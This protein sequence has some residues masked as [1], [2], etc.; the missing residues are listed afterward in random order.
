MGKI[1]VA[2]PILASAKEGIF[3]ATM[4]KLDPPRGLTSAVDL[5]NR[6]SEGLFNLAIPTLTSFSSLKRLA[7]VTFLS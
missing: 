1:A 5:Y 6:T 4:A 7:N 2:G 3:Q